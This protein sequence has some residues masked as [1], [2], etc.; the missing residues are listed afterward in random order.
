MDICTNR[1]IPTIAST[2]LVPRHRRFPIDVSPT[3]TANRQ[4]PR[5]RGERIPLEKR[6]KSFEVGSRRLN[7]PCLE[8]RGLYA[9]NW[10][11]GV[12]RRT[13]LQLEEKKKKASWLTA[14]P[15]F[16]V[17]FGKQRYYTCRACIKIKRITKFENCVNQGST[18]KTRAKFLRKWIILEIAL[19]VILF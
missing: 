13:K 17:H 11:L 12:H 16:L 1:E 7:P 10:D 8:R 9:R 4:H 18:C 15:T 3:R 5:P 14:I 19:K 6:I 2:N